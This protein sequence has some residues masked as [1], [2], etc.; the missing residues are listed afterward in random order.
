MN[1]FQ[2]HYI[3]I[4]KLCLLKIKL[5]KLSLV[6]LITLS[7]NCF[8]QKFVFDYY[9]LKNEYTGS[10]VV[11]SNAELIIEKAQNNTY[12]IVAYDPRDKEITLLSTIKFVKHDEVI[13]KYYYKGNIKL[14]EIDYECLIST[15]TKLSE[16]TK[17]EGNDNDF[18]FKE[19]YEIKFSYD[20]HNISPSNFRNTISIYPINDKGERVKQEK[21][22][23][24]QE[25]IELEEF[26]RGYKYSLNSREIISI[27]RPD[28]GTERGVR[29]AVEISVDSDGIVRKS[30]GGVKGS[31]TTDIPYIKAAEEAASKTI[32]NKT[33]PTSNLQKGTIYF[34]ATPKE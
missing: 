16:F 32:F 12:K 30:I 4:I 34:W 1:K 26:K 28:L 31:T 33:E 14:G 22:N 5:E 3:K 13:E 7:S 21:I 9:G 25:K 19:K 11:F 23:R 2:L 10:M 27:V 8:S 15:K 29:I 6:F 24:E 18:A 20:F 17:G